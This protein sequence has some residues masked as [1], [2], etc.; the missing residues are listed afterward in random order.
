M[1]GVLALHLLDL[2][3]F[4]ACFLELGEYFRTIEV[5][6]ALHVGAF[7]QVD[8]VEHAALRADAAAQALVGIHEGGAA[9][10]AACC[11]G[12]HLFLGEGLAV[13]LAALGLGCILARDLTDRVVVAVD[14][15]VVLV[16]HMEVVSLHPADSEAV[17]PDITVD[18]VG[19]FLTGCHRNRRD[20]I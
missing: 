1:F 15:E 17:A 5:V 4:P 7:P 19:A 2:D 8:G 9:A 14:D 13:V 10:Q 12:F 20:W 11:L 16:D 6:D 18:G 3:A